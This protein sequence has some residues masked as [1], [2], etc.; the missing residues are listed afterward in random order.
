[1]SKATSND[2][3]RLCLTNSESKYL[4]NFIETYHENISY[5][6]NTIAAWTTQKRKK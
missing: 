2:Y 4:E 5:K 6:E 3:K 1:M